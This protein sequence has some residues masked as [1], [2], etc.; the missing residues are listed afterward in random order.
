M[1]K[2]DALKEKQLGNEAYKKKDFANAISHYEKAISLDPT[3]L[4][5]HSNMAAVYFEMKDF[6]K[7]IK[8]CEKAIEVGRENRADFKLIAKA[9]ARMGGA[10]RKQ[11]NLHAAK[12]VME[13]ALTEHRTPEYKQTLSEVE[14]EIKKSEELAYLNPEVAEEEKNK[15]N[16]RFKAGDF[17]NAVKHYTEALKRN[18]TD[19]KIFSNRAACYTKLLSFDLAIKD[20]DKSIE[21]DPT[22]LKAYLRKGKVLQ[23]MGQQSKAMSVYEK[24]LELDAN[25]SEAMEGYRNCA[26]QS[27]A[28]KDPEE[29]RKNA[30]ND[31]EVQQIMGDPAMRM[32]LEQMQ[33]DPTALSEHMQNP[34]IAQK[35][36]K[37]RE[38]GLISVSYR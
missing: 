23:G 29:V 33:N 25:C 15:G 8:S 17:S 21:I 14:K 20:C 2:E 38:A 9:M 36:M 13:K 24:A 35:I 31:P 26:I 3:E 28:N 16:E 1:G 19:P 30:M 5:F 27:Q 12:T 10:Y 32:I 37:L 11:G 7:C 6:D 4:T 18:P 34:A 22:F